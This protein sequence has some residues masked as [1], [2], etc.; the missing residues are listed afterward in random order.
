[1]K[2]FGT[3]KLKYLKFQY[4]FV[5]DVNSIPTHPNSIPFW[6]I[7]KGGVDYTSGGKEIIT[8]WDVFY[9]V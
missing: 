2:F 4:V 8:P 6:E 9:T 1:M 7:Q 3:P 5:I